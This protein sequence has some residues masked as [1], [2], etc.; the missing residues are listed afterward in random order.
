MTTNYGEGRRVRTGNTQFQPLLQGWI[1]PDGNPWSIFVEVARV[2]GRDVPVGAAIRADR[3]GYELTQWVIQR[4]PFRRIITGRARTMDLKD[5][6]RGSNPHEEEP[7][8]RG[9]RRLEE[10]ELRE[11]ARLYRLAMEQRRP[12]HRYIANFMGIPQSTAAKRIRAARE[13]GFLD[14]PPPRQRRTRPRES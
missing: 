11:V 13:R 8:S 5:M 6:Y 1:G 10:D 14:L 7:R 4:I 3:E 2:D 12:I 9:S